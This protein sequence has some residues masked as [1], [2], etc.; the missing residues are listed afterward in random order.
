MMAPTRAISAGAKRR[1]ASSSLKPCSA[2]SGVRSSWE[3]I[4]TKSDFMRSISTTWRVAA[5]TFS[6]SSS[7]K[8]RWRAASRAFSSARPTWV[9]S[10]STVRRSSAPMSP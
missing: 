3:A 7:A 10:A 9:A 1:V 5:V 8:R 2:V 4:A 6:A